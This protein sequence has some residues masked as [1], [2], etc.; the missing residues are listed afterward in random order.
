MTEEKTTFKNIIQAMGL[1]FGDIG[2]SPIYTLTVI[3]LTTQINAQNILSI[4]SLIIWTL[5]LIV[6]IQ[7][8]WLAM[9]LSQKGEG[10]T[11]VLNELLKKLLKKGRSVAFFSFLTYVGISLLIG[12]SVITPAISILSAVE[13]LKFIH[14]LHNIPQSTILVIT[15]II[16]IALFS[17]QKKG[18]ENISKIFGPIMVIWFVA[19]GLSGLFSI[20]EAPLVLKAFNP[21]YGLEFLFKNGIA[22][23]FVLSEV[24]L[25]ATGAEALYADMGHLGRKPIVY[26]WYIVLFA[27][28]LNYLGQGA[29][30]L[31]HPDV[32]NI[33]F[34]MIVHQARFLYIPFLLVSL[35]ATIIASQ[36]MISGLF[37][38]IYQA[39]NTRIL[40][41]FRVEY[42]SEKINS[43]IY[44]PSANWFLMFFVI[45]VIL[46]FKES[47]KLASA[48]GFA[49]T[50]TFNITI[51]LIS[52]IF[53]LRK[54]YFHFMLALMLMIIDMS[55]LIAAFSKIH[56]G[57][58][59]S[60]IIATIPFFLIILY[61]KG[62]KAMYQAINLMDKEEF[63]QKYHE[64]YSKGSKIE[65]QALFFARGIEK[66]PPYV[67]QTM[68]ENSIMYSKNIFVHVNKSS[69]AF[70][71][72][73]EMET[74]AEG[75]QLLRIDAGYMQ[76]FNV[77]SVLKALDID[78][79]AI[80]Y[81]VEDIETN[82]F[83]WHIFS[84]IKKITPSFVSFY[85]L[86]TN[87]MHG[88]VTRLKL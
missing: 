62:Q 48:Y 26:A 72:H 1:V 71:L 50:G 61:V 33:L 35:M 34:S 29:F 63:L 49:V 14:F 6:T 46:F 38:I 3:F 67:V 4:L 39:I 15:L 52:I 51:I 77:D 11:I 5:L 53:F 80:F 40:P 30:L 88:V 20:L 70:G 74:V 82:N 66:V 37:A 27:L 54:K 60:I 23:F 31:K 42:T 86:P 22:G 44:I 85:N 21:I 56:T 55:F 83:F 2:T 18:T 57:A 25:C 12:D 87:K 47:S 24:I 78:G 59:W 19:L 13:G 36:A 68:F 65:G 84:T 17:I 64:R 73:Y 32:Q 28:L 43:Q 75:L 81:G 10:G 7:Y 45:F 9:S 8:T 16:A 41:L 79:K 76:L 58:Y 69:E